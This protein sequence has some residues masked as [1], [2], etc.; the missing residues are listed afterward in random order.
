M[1]EIAFRDENS[2]E[3]IMKNKNKLVGKKI[4]IAPDLTKKER[5]IQKEVIEIAKKNT[6]KGEKY[7]VSI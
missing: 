1:I 6:E 2:R 3:L 4:N 5:E 7:K